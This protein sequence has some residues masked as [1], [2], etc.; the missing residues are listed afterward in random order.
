MYSKTE[1][2]EKKQ[3]KRNSAE[4]G[5]IIAMIKKAKKDPEVIA[6][7]KEFYKHHTGKEL[8]ISK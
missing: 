5:K 4:A 2:I 7:A 6:A 3:S 1:T 8:K